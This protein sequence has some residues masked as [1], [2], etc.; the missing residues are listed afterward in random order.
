MKNKKSLI[1]FAAIASILLSACG[2]TDSSDSVS[3]TEEALLISEFLFEQYDEGMISVGEVVKS[4]TLMELVEEETDIYKALSDNFYY[5]RMTF[6]DENAVLITGESLFQS[7]RGY[8]ITN[9]AKISE[10]CYDVPE[11]FGFDA[12]KITVHSKSEKYEN[13]YFWTAGL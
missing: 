6:I 10:G 12:N 7:V 5:S 9:G 13:L 4:E 2:S 8:L 11:G 1:L 3:K